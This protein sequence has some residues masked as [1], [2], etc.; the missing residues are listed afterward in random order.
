MPARPVALVLAIAAAL[1][2][3]GPARALDLDLPVPGRMVASDS[4]PAARL[5]LPTGPAEAREV[6]ARLIEGAVERQ[7]WQMSLGGLSVAQL[8]VKL[9][10]ALTGAGYAI[11]F[12]CADR[13]CGG[14][15]FRYALDL[16]PEPDMHVDLG[17]YRYILALREGRHAALVVS[18]G[19]ETGYLHVTTTGPLDLSA[20]PLPEPA[21]LPA[22][23]AP[24]AAAPEPPRPAP[25]APDAPLAI[26]LAADG[27]AA[28]DDLDFESGASELSGRAFPSLTELAVWLNANPA[29]R[30][31]LVGHTD[32]VGGL[33]PNIALSQARA[34][35]VRARLIAAHGVAEGQVTAAGI[36]FLAPRASNA[37]EA[38][39]ALNRRVEVVVT[40][41]G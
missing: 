1:A 30:V 19:G 20:A 10:E 38:G 17:D 4:A 37:T 16:L 28:L 5:R 21:P 6:P 31:A 18:R 11:L 32:S 24:P 2:L 29:R 41:G 7:A 40:A 26:R 13:D 12:E 22:P 9:R 39:R 34:E 36:G 14:F 27:H 35:A 3:A 25:A 33:D 8:A 15:D 23:T